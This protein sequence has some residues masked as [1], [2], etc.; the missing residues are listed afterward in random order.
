MEISNISKFSDYIP[1]QGMEIH[2]VYSR[3]DYER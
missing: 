3:K 2:E 1:F